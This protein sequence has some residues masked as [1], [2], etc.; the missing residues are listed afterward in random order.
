MHF[1][2]TEEVAGSSPVPPTY[3]TPR[4]G[5]FWFEVA[6]ELVV[7]ALVKKLLGSHPFF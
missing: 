7:E 4:N 1:S 5:G 3:E 2:Y 6:N